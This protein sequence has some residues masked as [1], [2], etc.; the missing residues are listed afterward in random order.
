MQNSKVRRRLNIAENHRTATNAFRCLSLLFEGIPAMSMRPKIRLGSFATRAVLVLAILRLACASISHA[1]FIDFACMPDNSLQTD[2]EGLIY[3]DPVV[4]APGHSYTVTI[5]GT[6]PIAVNCTDTE[7]SVSAWEWPDAP[8]WWEIGPGANYINLSNLT[9]VSATQTTFDV[10]VDGGA[11][12]GN[13]FFELA[14]VPGFEN[15]WQV[16][17]QP[18]PPP[19]PPSPPP[20]PQLPCPNPVLDPDNPVTPDTWLPGQTYQITVKGTGFTTKAM[21][22]LPYCPA[23]TITLSVK[24]GT[25]DLTNIV[26]VNSTTIT[27]TVAPAK[28]DPGEPVTIMIWGPPEFDDDDDD[29][30]TDSA[31]PQPG[32]AAGALIDSAT[33]QLPAS[34]P[35]Q[36]PD[37]ASL[38]VPVPPG[39]VFETAS[40][41]PLDG[42]LLREPADEWRPAPVPVVGESPQQSTPT[43]PSGMVYD[44]QTQAQLARLY[45]IDPYLPPF[46]G[47][48]NISQ[49]TVISSLPNYSN[50][51]AQGLVT[52]GSATA[53]AV[54]QLGLNKQVTFKA[55]DGI[56]F[57]SWSP[58][59]LSYPASYGNCGGTC[60]IAVNPIQGIDGNYYAFALVLAPMQ[61]KSVT[62]G[63]SA[64]QTASVIASI[65]TPSGTVSSKP[66]YLGIG[67]TPVILVHGLWSS[68]TGMDV[69]LA[70][71]QNSDPWIVWNRIVDGGIFETCYANSIPFDAVGDI[72]AGCYQSS[73]DALKHSISDVQSNL[74][75]VAFVGGRVDIVAHSM[76]GLATRNYTS[77]SDYTSD[78]NKAR[79]RTEGPLRTIITVDTPET[80]SPLATALL[81]SAISGGT[82]DLQSPGSSG[83]NTC[84]FGPLAGSA[85]L[86]WR[87]AC[88]S[89]IQTTL[90]QCLAGHGMRLGPPNA[91]NSI[92]PCTAAKQAA[93]GATC[94]AVASLMPGSYNINNLPFI[95]D[96]QNQNV[97]WFAIGSDWKDTGGESP[98]LLR[99]FFNDL[100]EAMTLH[101]P[102]PPGLCPASNNPSPSPPTLLCMMGN[103]RDSDVIVPTSSQSDDTN[104][105]YVQFYNR[106]HAP[107]LPWFIPNVLALLG[108]SDAN[109]LDGTAD[110]CIKQILSTSSIQ[111][112]NSAPSSQDAAV[113]AA[114]SIVSQEQP[115]VEA[116]PGE[117][118]EDARE[119]LTHPM[120]MWAQKI[121]IKS[122]E[123]DIPLGNPVQLVLNLSPG[124]VNTILYGESTGTEGLNT[125]DQGIAR[126][127][128]DSENT[129]T[130]E[131]TPL[132]L[133]ALDVSVVAVY[134]DNSTGEQSVRLNVVPSATGLKRFD[135]DQGFHAITL[136]LNGDVNDGQHW[137][138]P[139]LAYS[140]VKFPI[141]LQDS[142]QIKFSILQDA[143]V[144]A[145]SLDSNGLIHGLHP[146]IAIIKG[147]FAGMKD[148]LKV[149]VEVEGK[150]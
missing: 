132:Q 146:G 19:N 134:G 83:V 87:A 131:L 61:G 129:K 65:A 42:F 26:V 13:L 76:G 45:I 14:S 119:R 91:P 94:G 89:N 80:G 7:V 23:T 150:Q 72:G 149:E 48:T 62:Y 27:A 88:G 38:Q 128:R 16:A 130:I 69:Q 74:D 120:R 141:R 41:E 148:E 108:K 133:G 104:G 127:A 73:A 39:N 44:G 21:S 5:T 3:M 12:S 57:E 9:W 109:I 107:T 117:S 96:I 40:L 145:I 35:L 22:S 47:S 82:C 116:A 78:Q 121:E 60:S 90:A 123:S 86:T 105:N 71:L 126:V 52:D 138:V 125:D 136:K 81:T 59:F 36:F 24:T 103:D 4:W 93:Y 84:D 58:S 139:K 56:Q 33:L 29:Q 64:N 124:K 2:K 114:Q 110:P 92:L 63:P 67:P 135:L 147:D 122:P 53:I 144:P 79:G 95:N 32:A 112:C 100:L 102:M 25:V 115:A 50:I 137:L 85:A 17:I 106:A 6:F 97:N 46:S 1:Q 37:S 101:S 15:Y 68:A 142:S 98:S 28:T 55:T 143:N 11:P 111:G 70:D 49:D 118:Q 20:G 77:T 10:S 30:G 140:G 54:Y 99:A 43:G 75:S 113:P 31:A 66:A 34:A 51:Q 8:D 18:P